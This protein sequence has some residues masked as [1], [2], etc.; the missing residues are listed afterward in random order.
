[1]N[2]FDLDKLN[3]ALLVSK[4]TD[5][6]VNTMEDGFRMLVDFCESHGHIPDRE[7]HH[8]RTVVARDEIMGMMLDDMSDTV[9]NN[10]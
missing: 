3:D 6:D 4:C 2:T 7:F 9:I 10:D 8:N 1:M 5:E